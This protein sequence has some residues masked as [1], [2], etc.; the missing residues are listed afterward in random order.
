MGL[1]GQKRPVVFYW[2]VK[3]L[4]KLSIWRGYVKTDFKCVTVAERSFFFFPLFIAVFCNKIFPFLL[5]S[6]LESSVLFVDSFTS[7]SRR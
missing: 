3:S 7:M 5:K 1:N 2:Y 4:C 6:K